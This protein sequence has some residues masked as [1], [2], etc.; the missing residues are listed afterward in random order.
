MET[1]NIY[2]RSAI[3]KVQRKLVPIFA[4]LLLLSFIDR[5]NVAFAALEMNK[6]LGFSPTVYATAVSIFFIGYIIFEIPSNYALG[7]FG[8]KKWLGLIIF[9]WGIASTCLFLVKDSQSFY[10]LR[11][12]LGVAEAGLLPG[13]LLYMTYWFPQENRGKINAWILVSMPLSI[14]IGGPVSGLIL[15]MPFFNGLLGLKTWQWMFIIEGLPAVIA[16]VL[17]A[18]F[19]PNKPKDAK[20]LSSNELMALQSLLDSEKAVAVKK[21]AHGFLRGIFS[22]PVLLLAGASFGS[23]FSGFG[24]IFWMPQILK[25]FSFSVSQIGFLVALPYIFALLGVLLFGYLGDKTGRYVTFAAA[26]MIAASIALI[27]SGFSHQPILTIVLFCIAAIGIFGNM[28]SFWALPG[29]YLK[30]DAVAGSF[31]TINTIGAL[32]GFFGPYVVGRLKES[33]GGFTEALVV[34]GCGAILLPIF[35]AIF[36]KYNHKQGEV[37]A[38]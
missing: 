32:G 2:L 9:L 37:Y 12:L 3:T 1:Q 15:G 34:L 16:G 7:I 4:V 21:E 28:P 35:L 8:A 25:G 31:A 10:L 5:S 19:L 29:K 24:L 38:K 27:V 23:Q 30:G 11:F 36:V 6:D 17:I 14:V 33:S 13:I 22:L 26:P 18:I 20:W